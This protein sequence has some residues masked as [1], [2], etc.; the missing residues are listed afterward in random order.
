MNLLSIFKAAICIALAMPTVAATSITEAPLYHTIINGVDAH[1]S[2]TC[3]HHPLATPKMMPSRSKKLMLK[4][5]TS[6]DLE[7]LD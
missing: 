5:P 6:F 1:H 2:T 3:Y 7:Y 4:A